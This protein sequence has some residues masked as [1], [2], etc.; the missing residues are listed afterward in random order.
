M[1]NTRWEKVQSDPKLIFLSGNRH[2]GIGPRMR[3]SSGQCSGPVQ[4]VVADFFSHTRQKNFHVLLTGTAV[5]R[6]AH[7]RDLRKAREK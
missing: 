7:V 4:S 3:V 6:N 5:K 1:D 2:S